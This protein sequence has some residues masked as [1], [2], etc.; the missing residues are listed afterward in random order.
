MNIIFEKESTYSL[1][2][3]CMLMIIASHTTINSDDSLYTI[4][5][6]LLFDHWGAFGTGLF[7][8]LSGYGMF[9]SLQKAKEITATYLLN[10]LRKLF[11]PFFYTWIIYL[12]FFLLFDKSQINLH[13][14][15]EF[16]T[17]SLPLGIDAWFFK[18]I[19]G[20]YLLII[21]LFRIPISNGLRITIMSI[22]VITYYIVFRELSFGPWWY[23]TV[24]NFPLGMLFAWRKEMVQ[25]KYYSLLIILSTLALSFFTT[26][27]FFPYICFSLC[28][29]WFARIIK[30]QFITGLKFIG[31]NSL[32]F[33]LLECPSFEYL[34]KYFSE[35]FILSFLIAVISTTILAM[36]YLK[37]ERY[38]NMTS[39][40][41]GN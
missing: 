17:L 20:L 34:T 30:I 13:L 38:W 7:F 27:S 33:Y 23:N 5:Q 3:I 19:L 4:L 37:I 16:I 21:L 22:L 24:L 2:G 29:I 1:R 26:I 10:K 18:V 12:L 35:S 39:F 25:N 14:L 31:I 9:L 32:L 6:F 36:I 40:S 41:R 11:L 15:S 28:A 8:L